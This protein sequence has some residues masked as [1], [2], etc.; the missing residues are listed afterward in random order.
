[1]VDHLNLTDNHTGE[2][3]L[4]DVQT[5]IMLFKGTFTARTDSGRVLRNNSE[6]LY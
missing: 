4:L 2:Q 5:T 3:G 1:M 6:V